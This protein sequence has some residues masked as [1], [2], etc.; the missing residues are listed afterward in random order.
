[1]Q[2]GTGLAKPSRFMLLEGC[3]GSLVLHLGPCGGAFRGHLMLHLR[4]SGLNTIAEQPGAAAGL[5]G[6]EPLQ[7]GL[8]LQLS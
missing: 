6:M 7:R 2:P 8:M 4:E 5:T 1:M 3:Q